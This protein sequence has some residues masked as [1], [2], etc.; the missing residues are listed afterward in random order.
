MGNEVSDQHW[1]SPTAFDRLKREYEHL[2]T[3]GRRE[4]SE[5][6]KHA[7]AHGDITESAE[8]DAAK[9]R[10]GLMEARIRE[11]ERLLKDAMVVS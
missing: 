11:L 8:Y 3:E 6:I 4:A 10:Q 2:S 7:R 5:Q 9:D 1:L